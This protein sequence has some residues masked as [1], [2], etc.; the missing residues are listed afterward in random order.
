MKAIQYSFGDNISTTKTVL[1]STYILFR[2]FD[3]TEW[4]D[5]NQDKKSHPEPPIR[6]HWLSC[7]LYEIFL[8][9]PVYKYD[10][11]FFIKDSS[12]I[13]VEAEIAFGHI[14]GEVPD[15]RGIYDVVSSN[16]HLKYLQTIKDKWKTIRPHLVIHKRGGNLAD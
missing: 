1:F 3:F 7:T 16:F 15:V 12:K 2:L 10:A 14:K 6:M 5:L 9:R 13:I 8:K 11:N 4:D